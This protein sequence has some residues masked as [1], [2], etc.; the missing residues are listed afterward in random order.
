MESSTKSLFLVFALFVENV[1]NKH[2]YN[3]LKIPRIFCFWYFCPEWLFPKIFVFKF[4]LCIKV[5][6]L[7]NTT[8]YIEL[9]EWHNPREITAEISL[10][11]RLTGEIEAETKSDSTSQKPGYLCFQTPGKSASSRNGQN[12]QNR[13]SKAENNFSEQ[14]SGRIEIFQSMFAC[15]RKF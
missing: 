7:F 12:R 5:V 6:A 11:S 9:Q 15:Y 14:N 13:G 2:H 8:L 4:D 10:I 3:L 1:S